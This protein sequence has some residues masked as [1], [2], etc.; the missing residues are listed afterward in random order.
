MN[1]VTDILEIFL[2][3]QK[4]KHINQGALGA[5]GLVLISMIMNKRQNSE[6]NQHYR[7]L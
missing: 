5:L 3:N 4:R 1:D 7:F 2:E 6:N